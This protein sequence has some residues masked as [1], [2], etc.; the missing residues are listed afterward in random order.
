MT[1]NKNWQHVQVQRELPVLLLRDQV[2]VLH[3]MIFKTW[4]LTHLWTGKYLQGIWG[5][6]FVLQDSVVTL[7]PYDVL[8]ITRHECHCF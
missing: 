1:M 2:Q 8:D 6:V 5:L 7:Q 3:Q 4:S